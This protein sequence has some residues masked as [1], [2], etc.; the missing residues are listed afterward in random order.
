MVNSDGQ[1]TLEALLS[2]DSRT[3]TS[4]CANTKWLTIFQTIMQEP[5]TLKIINRIQRRYSYG[6]ML[7]RIHCFQVAKR[8]HEPD[9]K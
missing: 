2:T 5:W 7:S 9:Y 1:L 6:K 4:R 3:K 8:C